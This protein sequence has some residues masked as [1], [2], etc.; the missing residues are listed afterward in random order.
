[1][2]SL[3]LAVG[4]PAPRAE[5]LLRPRVWGPRDPWECEAT[6]LQGPGGS[7]EGESTAQVCCAWAQD[8]RDPRQLFLP[9]HRA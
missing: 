8:C 3:D 5:G 7:E 6:V 2:A 1:M 9:L 4:A